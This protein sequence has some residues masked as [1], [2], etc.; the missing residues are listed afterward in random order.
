MRIKVSQLFAKFTSRL[1]LSQTQKV[2]ASDYRP[3]CAELIE[4][5]LL[6]SADLAAMDSIA[7]CPPTPL[8][9]TQRLTSTAEQRESLELV[10]IDA[11]V[12]DASA[13]IADIAA[14]KQ[15]GR[16]I[17]LLYI[18]D[19]EDGVRAVSDRLLTLA[20]QGF[21]VSAIHIVSH[22]SDGEFDLGNQRVNE[23]LLRRATPLLSAWSDS[24]TANADI[25]SYGCNFAD[26][27][28]GISFAKNLAAITGADIAGNSD[29]TGDLALGG[30]WLLDFSTGAVEAKLAISESTQ[31]Q[32]HHL[33]ALDTI[34][35]PSLAN[36][37]SADPQSTGL[38]IDTSIA[39]AESTGGD[40]IAVDAAGNYVV[41]WI[42]SD[43]A[44]IRFF[45]ANDTPRTPNA[46]TLPKVS[47]P[48]AVQRQV[49]VAMNASG[50]TV[51]VWSEGTGSASSIYALRISSTG[52][53]AA[54]IPVRS[55][56][57]AMKPAVAINDAGEFVVA[58][59]EKFSSQGTDV[60]AQAYNSS[61]I[62]LGG[63]LKL[64]ASLDSS[65]QTRPSV[66]IA[67]STA[68]VAWHDSSN[69]SIMFKTVTVI[70]N[71]AYFG[72]ETQA[73]ATTG[74]VFV[75][76]APDVAI[77]HDSK[78][79]LTWQGFEA[80]KL[81]TYY[82]VFQT[83][84]LYT[85][86]PPQVFPETRVNP[87][88]VDFQ[89]L[90]KVAIADSGEFVI[91][92]Q[93]LGPADPDGL[94]V[95]A[96]SFSANNTPTAATETPVNYV[97]G[98]S[99]YTAGNQSAP[100][101]A[102][103]NGNIITAWTS[104]QNGNDDV[105]TRQLQLTTQHTFIVDTTYDVIDP[106]DGLTSFREAV[107]AANATANQGSTP[108]N[109]FFRIAGGQDHLLTLNN[110]LPPIVESV[111][112]DGF[113]QNLFNGGTITIV[114]QS[115]AF[116]TLQLSR[117]LGASLNSSGSTITGITI[118]SVI[119]SAIL[120]ETSLNTIIR[121]TLQQ[122]QSSGIVISGFYYSDAGQN[123]IESN[124]IYQNNGAGISIINSADNL[125]LNNTVSQNYGNG[126]A[127]NSVGTGQHS[128]HNTIAGNV[129]GG[130]ANGIQLNSE[131][132]SENQIIGNYIGV[133]KLGNNIGNLNNG[134]S[135]SFGAAS[136]SV[137]GIDVLDT[138]TIAY[139][140]E[141]GIN[142][143]AS[144]S[145]TP[146]NNHLLR[147]SLYANTN[148]G[149]NIAAQEIINAP[150]LIAITQDGISTNIVFQYQG[151][152][153]SYYRL[154]FFYSVPDGTYGFG[155]AKT[156]LG[157]INIQT[158][159]A[160][161]SETRTTFSVAAPVGSKVTATATATDPS[162]SQ[163]GSTSNISN[164]FS[165]GMWRTVAENQS[166][167]T[168]NIAPY[169]HDPSQTGLVYTLLPSDDT[170]HF[171]LTPAGQLSFNLPIDYEAVRNDLN[172]GADDFRWVYVNISNGTYYENVVHVF[173]FTDENDAPVITTGLPISAPQ[174]S[175]VSFTGGNAITVSD[176]DTS[177]L[178][179][180]TPLT[181]TVNAQIEG[182]PGQSGGLIRLAGIYDLSRTVT[183][184]V[185]EL[186]AYLADLQL[187][188]YAGEPRSVRVYLTVNDGGS[189]FGA[190]A[191]FE[192]DSSQLINITPFANVPPTISGLAGGT[193]YTE[194]SGAAYPLGSIVLTNSDGPTLSSATIT[195]TTGLLG[196]EETLTFPDATLF[197]LTLNHDTSTNTITI[198]GIRATADYQTF[199]RSILYENI[200]NAPRP[201]NRTFNVSINDGIDQSGVASTIVITQL[202]ND[203]PYISFGAN[204][205]YTIGFNSQLNFNAGLMQALDFGDPDFTAGMFSLVVSVP[206][207]PSAGNFS[208]PQTSMDAIK[209][210]GLT[211]IGNPLGDTT[212]I[213]IG[214][215]AL[216]TQAVG[217]LTY[218]PSSGH[219]GNEIITFSLS[220][221][222]NIG[223]GG[224]LMANATVSI[225][226]SAMLNTAPTVSGI[227]A[228]QIFTEGGSAV[229][230]FNGIAITD[231]QQTN[232]V[233]VR[234]TTGG[235]FDPLQDL[236]PKYTSRPGGILATRTG[237]ELLLYGT[238]P[239]SDYIS[240]LNTL[241]FIN[242]SDSPSTAA[243]T[244][245][246]EV[247]DGVSWST[248]VTTSITVA[249]IDDPLSL[250]LPLTA[251][252]PFGQTLLLSGTSSELYLIDPDAG[253]TVYEMA[254]S[255][256]QG[257]ASINGSIP[258]Q[259]VKI[260][261]T[262][263][264]LNTIL[265]TQQIAYTANAGYAGIDELSIVIRGIDPGTG[266]TLPLKLAS[267]QVQLT[268]LSG[269]PP[270][271]VRGE[272][273]GYFTE[274]A[275]PLVLHSAMQIGGGN[276]GMLEFAAVQ[277]VGGYDST[278][279]ILFATKVPTGIVANWNASTGTLTLT[280]SASIA[281]YEQALAS[282]AYDNTSQ[283]PSEVVRE[284]S[285]FA[286]DSL[287]QSNELL[288]SVVVQSVNDIP[289][290]TAPTS[291]STAEDTGMIFSLA[292][293]IK[294]DDI[295]SNQLTLTVSVRNGELRWIGAP[296]P[297]VG[298]RI[299]S[300]SSVELAGNALEINQ[301]AAQLEFVAPPNFNG[302]SNVQWTL[303]D[304][305]G[306][307]V[308]QLSPIEVTAVND[309]P[310]WK[311]LGT[312]LVDQGK[313]VALS[314]AQA[315]AFDVEDG[316]EKLTYL[317]SALPKNGSLEMNG[318]ALS[319]G[320]SFTQA[321]INN[322]AISYRNINSS[323]ASDSFSFSVRDSAGGSTTTN[324]VA[325]AISTA[326]II[327]IAPPSGGGSTSGGGT[328]TPPTTG[329][330]GAVIDTKS[331]TGPTVTDQPGTIASSTPNSVPN[332]QSKLVTRSPSNT[333]NSLSTGSNQ[334][335]V[336][337]TSA[338]NSNNSFSISV[339]DS[340]TASNVRT[341]SSVLSKTT[342]DDTTRGEQNLASGFLKVRT[343][344]EN[345][346][347]AAIL[348]SAIGNQA[349]NDDV[350]RVR[351][352][353][354]GKLK[355]NQNVVASTT[356][357]SATLSIGYVIW[358]VRGGA[359]LSSLLAS[360]PAWRLVDPL[361]IL[362]SMGGNEDDSDDESL[363]EMIKKSKASRAQAAEQAAFKP[364]L[365]AQ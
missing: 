75:H 72:V 328:T 237:N 201:L 104:A 215:K 155:V 296:S 254:V 130:N 171:S 78:I 162:Y 73:N 257:V 272:S 227:L 61:S 246:I 345:T 297:Q 173:K 338:S 103:R 359:L 200:S 172:G 152:P 134:I 28:K 357:V 20:E 293:A 119:G 292:N 51:V 33:L 324:T 266:N 90:P 68:V 278:T 141:Y 25:L 60:L 303:L 250:S 105:F 86:V 123:T 218:S 3:A 187:A 188:T 127:L 354:E 265:Q 331:N 97:S 291:L 245:S 15:N 358:L 48:G 53:A 263:D 223:S 81:R 185:A 220:D 294:A 233:A 17:E 57:Q 34:G 178:A 204:A 56:D 256:L 18:A 122:S 69:D 269:L 231:T 92:Q 82:S 234:V 180:S 341:G 50:E 214:V 334:G 27:E 182:Q 116:A 241:F 114:D 313:S 7:P 262:I 251:V 343:V 31:N 16:N 22:G 91:I 43:D 80:T 175:I 196:T 115:T 37:V 147:N 157:S 216:I 281:S 275:G 199:I 287:Q 325:I 212:V 219:T 283:N 323:S 169:V 350:Q 271:L 290:L 311:S 202:V 333:T 226:T 322:G 342:T 138:N 193:F 279:D 259:E 285:M 146:S 236:Q 107:I 77:N 89:S 261:G 132:T 194:N 277:I 70:S 41:V 108:D 240:A 264:S 253:T 12:A 284:I 320:A 310:T 282:V 238:L 154:E 315:Q 71:V 363:D 160:G 318:V 142:V 276:N 327:V 46:Y 209:G 306:A 332:T 101:I 161:L 183:G 94:G 229:A 111:K 164:P 210:G 316:A 217:L 13:L 230:I 356:A 174:G 30:D 52:F 348:R 304:S 365:H 118:R 135:F 249:P 232:L 184:T 197:G 113:T 19:D 21:A 140:G 248:P 39:T 55:G 120:I 63:P 129:I 242:T 330:P 150:L 361:P 302:M 198:S 349:F 208:Y 340:G 112:I 44:K 163:F 42:D 314:N 326:P 336:G 308:T 274:D 121:N 307:S 203:A 23:A 244:F 45:N 298:V 96:R 54:P 247:F 158:D 74:S 301:L 205:N 179:L 224:S 353:A 206:N 10:V 133:D 144:V 168:Y 35:T 312:L 321:D 99:A 76:G 67:G 136:N 117:D 88:S 289:T 124:V 228:N 305:Q 221:N 95:L 40:K 145:G 85:L 66:A 213:L 98:N 143:A 191:R 100:A 280:G 131:N 255:A 109:I 24:L 362:G 14:Q 309:T 125:I 167:Q 58:W 29:N 84:T 87:T 299:V 225:T 235:A 339:A 243:R 195:Y 268:V 317:L 260:R 186:N 222:G 149:I 258:A 329:G 93:S 59:Q 110:A 352:D 351:S 170:Y 177:A 166:P 344:A 319:L 102:W 106:Y 211:V 62:A 79:V 64:N 128:R 252:V 347:Y 300:A 47:N 189:G 181:L 38:S 137:G 32:W 337:I 355:F 159:S 267:N 153:N 335:D 346:E 49:A 288:I 65:D 270:E 176:Q 148:G 11:K 139:N 5:R 295:D 156:F 1:M 4:P 273:K 8:L 286:S 192:T 239:I 165:V 190:A 26:S 36:T 151:A 6:Y 83:P 360:I 2:V 207:S 364:E 126:I 9:Q